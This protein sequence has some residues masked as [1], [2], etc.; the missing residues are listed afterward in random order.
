[1]TEAG[2]TRT[3][4][5]VPAAR[6]APRASGRAG[7]LGRAVPVVAARGLVAAAP[8][9]LPGPRHQHRVRA[10]GA[11]GAA[12]ARATPP[13][14]GRVRQADADHGASPSS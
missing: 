1:M 13:F 10:R 4:G 8:A 11:L 2:R 5:G 6:R 14:R 7:G 9:G 3:A 12:G